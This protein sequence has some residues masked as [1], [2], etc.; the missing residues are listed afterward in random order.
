MTRLKNEWLMNIEE[1][2]KTSQEHLIRLTGRNYRNL[3]D[4]ENWPT[5]SPRIAIIPITQGEGIIE[6]FS[7]S[8]GAILREMGFE[9]F[10]TKNTDVAGILE[11][12]EKNGDILFMADDLK[13]I[14]WNIQSGIIVDNDYATAL[15]YVSALEGAIGPLEDKRV[16]VMGFGPLGRDFRQILIRKGAEVCFFE[17]D[18][19]KRQEIFELGHEVLG[20]LEEIKTFPYLVD[21]TNTGEWLKE[22]FLH[23]KAWIAAPGVPLSLDAETA[24]KF[25]DR[26]IHDLLPIGVASMLRLVV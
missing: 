17:Q 18:R 7:L 24:E 20:S 11:A 25:Q 3:I 6:Y 10:V 14:A 13:F 19:V 23:P 16:L 4:G 5:A 8:I 21:A 2:L 12:R 1:E 22:E 26:L 15:G 9:V